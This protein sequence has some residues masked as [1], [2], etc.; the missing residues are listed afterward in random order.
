MKMSIRNGVFETNSSSVHTIVIDTSGNEDEYALRYYDGPDLGFY[1]REFK[2]VGTSE[3]R[4]S[5]LW[6]AIWTIKNKYVLDE[7]NEDSPYAEHYHRLKDL[8]DLDW[9]ERYLYETWSGYYDDDDNWF[10]VSADDLTEREKPRFQ[11]E[12]PEID[13]DASFEYRMLML[14]KGVDHA[15]TLVTFFERVAKDRRLLH[16]FIFGLGSYVVVT[17]DEGGYELDVPRMIDS[18]IIMESIRYEEEN[19]E[20]G[21]FHEFPEQQRTV[22][23]KMG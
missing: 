15:D 6:T 17:N 16:D 14:E 5:Y 22:F 11:E 12:L 4:V 3:D 10:S 21:E 9:W 1:G 20:W 19:C 18:D 7:I 8:P 2:V 23:V 13:E